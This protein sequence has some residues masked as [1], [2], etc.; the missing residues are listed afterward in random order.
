MSRIDHTLAFYSALSGICARGDCTAREAADVVGEALDYANE[1]VRQTEGFLSKASPV[2]ALP[3]EIAETP[4]KGLG[5]VRVRWAWEGA[6]DDV[7]GKSIR[8]L[9]TVDLRRYSGLLTW[10]H[11]R[12]S[13]LG[14]TGLAESIAVDAK[15][16]A[17]ELTS[18]DTKANE[19][20]IW[21]GHT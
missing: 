2:V 15:A 11:K 5:D 17:E 20:M 19:S 10:L 4:F 6:P 8:T 18:R 16:V 1:A 3:S 13:G 7:R 12:E 9:S 21:D 14:L